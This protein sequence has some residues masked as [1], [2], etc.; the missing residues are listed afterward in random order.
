MRKKNLLPQNTKFLTNFLASLH[1]IFSKHTLYSL[2]AV[3]REKIPL[4]K[5]EFSSTMDFHQ[6][7]RHTLARSNTF[8]VTTPKPMIGKVTRNTLGHYYIT[9][10]PPKLRSFTA[11]NISTQTLP[12]TECKS[13]STAEE[14]NSLHQEGSEFLCPSFGPIRNNNNGYFADKEC[15]TPS[16]VPLE[17]PS[18]IAPSLGASRFQVN[19]KDA[20][21]QKRNT[22]NIYID[23]SH[24]QNN[25]QQSYG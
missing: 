24:T 9:N 16:T 13:T 15:S 25:G 20:F 8:V 10:L 18:E 23:Y 21:R 11:R 12:V 3:L 2:T 1:Q 5:T 14:E 17:H 6:P 19:L 4:C 7:R 22:T